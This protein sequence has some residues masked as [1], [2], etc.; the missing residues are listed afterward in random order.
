MFAETD[1]KSAP[2]RSRGKV[3]FGVI[4]DVHRHYFPFAAERLEKFIKAA[5]KAKVDFIISLGD[6]SYPEEKNKSFA[7]LWN[8][9]NGARF[10]VLGNH[11]MDFASKEAFLDFVGQAKLGAH[12]SFERGGFH[13]IV[14]DDNFIRTD[15]GFIPYDTKNYVK[16][17]RDQ[18]AYIDPGQL[19]WLEKE[20]GKASKP[21]VVFLHQP[22][23]TVGNGAE[24]IEIFKHVNA[25]GKKV[26]AVFSGHKH[27]NWCKTED[28]IH[29]V[30]INSASY[31]YVGPS[32]PKYHGRY[33][34]ELEKRFPILPSIAPYDD[35]L[36][37]IIDLNGPERKIDIEGR[38]A[39]FVAPSPYDLGYF[40]DPED[41]MSP[42]SKIDSR[43]LRF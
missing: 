23:E 11:D 12:Y 40:T 37:A 2:I 31:F 29:H 22:L 35:A 39:N 24:V 28:D 9:F 38:Q 15:D 36:F 41:Q 19:N 34:E 25:K 33:P 8:S 3:R 10:H 13:F 42:S 30:Q 32:K 4:A 17:K 14:L 6:F 27:M 5:E 7:T 43:V 18:I 20:L 21:V 1:A 26:I 16:Y